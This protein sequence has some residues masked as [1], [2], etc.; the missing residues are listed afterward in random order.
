MPTLSFRKPAYVAALIA[1]FALI[2]F[3]STYKLTESPPTWYDEGIYI[4]V[5]HSFATVGTQ[6]MQVAPG[7]FRQIDFL[8]VGYPVLAPVA[9]SLKLFG[10]SV[11]A[12]RIPMV[13]FILLF[14]ASTWLLLSRLTKP[15][16]ALL[17]LALLATFPILYGNGKNVLGEVPG[18]LYATLAF[19]ALARLEKNNFKGP[20]N[21]LWLGLAVGLTAATKPVFLLLPAA[22]GLVLLFHVRTIL[23]RVVDVVIAALAFVVPLLLWAF[24]QFGADANL[25]AILSYYANPYGVA[26]VSATVGENLLRFFNEA[27]PLYCGALMSLWLASVCVR[28]YMKEKISLAEQSAFVFSMLVLLAYLRTAGWYRYFFQSITLAL[29]FAPLSLMTLARYAERALGYK[30]AIYG[31]AA[32]ACVGILFCMQLYQLNLS[33]WV[34]DHYASTNVAQTSSFFTNFPKDKSILVYNSPEAVNTIG[35]MNYYQY[36]RP[37]DSITYG[38][39]ALDALKDTVPDY[40]LIAPGNYEK[41]KHLFTSYNKNAEAGPYLLLKKI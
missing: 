6:S 38:S 34:A 30:S 32:I 25:S 36:M 4:Q 41:D 35:T 21:Y 18:L 3:Y 13:M 1:I 11:F 20:A 24:L 40:V 22:M 33:S 15:R 16:E 28:I 29:I 23:P 10:L 37:T 8:T 12:A 39:E 26:S 5:A 17:G 2:L 9:L 7:E 27:T 31:Y 14:A 19:L